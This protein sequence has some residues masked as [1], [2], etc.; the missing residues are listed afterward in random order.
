MQNRRIQLE[1]LLNRAQ[2]QQQ[3]VIETSIFHLKFVSILFNTKK[4]QVK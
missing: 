2:T 1:D 3:Q 4:F